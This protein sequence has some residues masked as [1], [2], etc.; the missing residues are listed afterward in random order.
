MSTGKATP[1]FLFVLERSNTKN[2]L[3]VVTVLV[4]SGFLAAGEKTDTD[5]ALEKARDVAH[6]TAE[7]TKEAASDAVAATREIA[8]ATNETTGEAMGYVSSS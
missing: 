4:A 3:F 2:R 5:A 6:E 7:A 1:A 8:E